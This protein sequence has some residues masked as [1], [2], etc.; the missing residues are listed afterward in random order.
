MTKLFHERLEDVNGTLP[1][2]FQYDKFDQKIRYQIVNLL[3]IAND[4]L[5]KCFKRIA[6][7]VHTLLLCSLGTPNLLTSENLNKLHNYHLHDH[8]YHILNY[9]LNEKN[10]PHI[11][12]CIELILNEISQP[13]RYA[14]SVRFSDLCNMINERLK[15]AG[16]GWFYQHPFIIKIEDELFNKNATLPLI[17]RLNNI[18]YESAYQHY[19][20]AY[21]HLKESKNNEAITSICKAFESLIKS[22]I[23][24]NEIKSETEVE[25]LQMKALIDYFMD[26]VKSPKYMQSYFQNLK[27]ILSGQHTT[28]NKNTAHGQ[29]NHNHIDNDMTLYLI[30]MATANMLYI[31]NAS[32]N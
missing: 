10:I 17:S 15:R 9:I 29:I 13:L 27:S 18:K 31:S 4:E 7:K 25:N 28:R 24:T 11:L 21:S 16:I 19:I 32:K 23:V 12:S 6:S 14:S 30:N 5:F 22:W 20:D 3:K 1:K 8:D 2:I 26:N